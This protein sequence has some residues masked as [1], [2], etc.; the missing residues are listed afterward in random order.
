MLRILVLSIFLL[1][2][3]ASLNAQDSDSVAVKKT[4]P[5]QEETEEVNGIFAFAGYLG[6]KAYEELSDQFSDE[7][8]TASKKTKKVKI[9]LG[10]IKI[11][12]IEKR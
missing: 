9:K 6:K 10:P 2:C 1:L 8:D 3:S 12:R 5:Q 4:E 11:E 7:K